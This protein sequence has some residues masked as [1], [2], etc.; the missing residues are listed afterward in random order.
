MTPSARQA[1]RD[2]LRQGAP[3]QAAPRAPLPDLAKREAA[4]ARLLGGVVAPDADRQPYPAGV[5]GQITKRADGR[6]RLVTEL[7]VEVGTVILIESGEL[8]DL[9]EVIAGEVYA[10]WPQFKFLDVRLRSTFTEQHEHVVLRS[11]AIGQSKSPSFTN[12][13]DLNK[14]PTSLRERR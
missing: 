5:A 14:A 10:T 1:L 9:L 12:V 11:T 6:I 13:G 8:D 3:D 7:A 4:R 2:R